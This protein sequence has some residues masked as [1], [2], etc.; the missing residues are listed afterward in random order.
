MS[1]CLW[2]CTY[3]S[4][5]AESTIIVSSESYNL[6]AMVAPLSAGWNVN[7]KIIVFNFYLFNNSVSSSAVKISRLHFKCH[8]GTIPRVTLLNRNVTLPLVCTYASKKAES[9]N[10]QCNDL[11]TIIAVGD[12]TQWHSLR[13]R[14]LHGVCKL[15]SRKCD[16]HQESRRNSQH[17]RKFLRLSSHPA[18]FNWHFRWVSLSTY[19]LPRVDSEGTFAKERA[20]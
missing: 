9:T 2:V 1:L 15:C 20:F 6:L 4:K 17:K 7:R 10:C 19:V 16:F 5:K 3:A 11:G 13:P 8:S 12:T 14:A 18:I